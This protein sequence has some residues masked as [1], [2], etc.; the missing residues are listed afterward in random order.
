MS[1]ISRTTMIVVIGLMTM[2]PA[3]TQA[4]DGDEPFAQREHGQHEAQPPREEGK[5]SWPASIWAE[6]YESLN[7]EHEPRPE[8]EL[9]ELEARMHRLQEEIHDLRV[10]EAEFV[11]QFERA[12]LE[13]REEEAHDLRL[14]LLDVEHEIRRRELD[15]ARIERMHDNLEERHELMRMTD[16]LEYVSN[17]GDVAFNAPRAVMMA[18][19][20][21][22]ETALVQGEPEHGVSALSS[23]LENVTHLG[24]R[25]AVR[26]ALKDIYTAMGKPDEAVQQMALVI[27]ENADELE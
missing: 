17:W 14:R 15:L 27:Q 23:I 13:Q 4:V 8:D 18:T 10:E 24:S 26:F 11:A 21:I 2:G 22:V 7:E 19:Q 9:R 5:K 6:E 12:H 25:T 1:A 16:R 20:A 3:S